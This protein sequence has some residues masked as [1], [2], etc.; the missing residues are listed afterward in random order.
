MTAIAISGSKAAD[1]IGIAILLGLILLMGIRVKFSPFPSMS[2]R[3]QTDS[4]GDFW[5]GIIDPARATDWSTPPRGALEGVIPARTTICD[6]LSAGVTAAQINSAIASCPS[7]QTVFLNAGTYS[8]SAMID[9]GSKSNVTLRGA[10]AD[11]TI[12][13]FSATGSCD[14][15]AAAICISS[16]GVSESAP[17]NT[18]TWTA[19]YSVGTTTITVGNATNMAVGHLIIL[20]QLDDTVDDGG[21]YVC[22]TTS[23]SDEGGNSPGRTNRG[24]LHIAR[25][26]SKSGNDVTIHP[27][28][29]MPNW[30][31]G[32]TPGVWWNASAP[33]ITGDGIEDLT[34]DVTD[35]T[36]S[37]GIVLLHIMDSW[38]KGVRGLNADR[39]HVWLYKS[40]QMTVRDSYFYGGQGDHSQSYG[41][42]G[43]ATGWNL[44]ENNIFNHVT[45]PI[46]HNGSEHGSVVAYNFSIDDNYTA[47]GTAPG[48]EI[49]TI[50]IHEVGISYI[51]HEGNDGLGYLHDN[52]HGTVHF[53]T[54]FR[55]HFY[56]DVWNNPAKT[57][58]TAIINLASYG[59]FFNVVGNILGRTG[60]YDTYQTTLTEDPTSIYALGWSPE[61]GVPDD[62]RVEESLFRWGNYDTVTDSIRFQ[63]SETP[64]ADAFFPNAVPSSQSMPP[65]FYLESG[66]PS[67]WSTPWGTPPWPPIGPDVTGGNI[68]GWD[69]HANKIPARLCYENTTKVGDVL[70][71]NADSCY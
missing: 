36:G 48:W 17:P 55:N 12:L 50:G 64:T 31:S 41:V 51:L 57:D 62:D 4:A 23:C 33:T 71:F 26:V 22:A 25:V 27:P 6:T 30:R 35:A 43:Y 59:R 9:F 21:I 19:G 54:T 53:M 68:T 5:E 60:Y 3:L 40:L 16:G 7:G 37:A 67:F 11:Q 34:V 18:T 10:G 42:E 20:D 63:S 39:S 70:V 15:L 56:G 58:N 2:A 14:G 66:P 32:Q 28:L 69:G 29:T 45:G 49:P 61:V 1:K 44:I 47:E 24:Q 38:V 65:S 46:K 52:I 8:L 13:D